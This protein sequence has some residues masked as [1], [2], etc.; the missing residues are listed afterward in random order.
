[1][2]KCNPCEGKGFIKVLIPTPSAI[3]VYQQQNLECKFCIGKGEFKNAEIPRK[4]TF[5]TVQIWYDK[6]AN[7]LKVLDEYG[8]EVTLINSKVVTLIKFLTDSLEYIKQ[9][10][11]EE[12]VK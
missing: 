10:D 2:V 7:R 8:Q 12:K 4:Y 5:E 11:S 6:S 1:M 3:D 9:K